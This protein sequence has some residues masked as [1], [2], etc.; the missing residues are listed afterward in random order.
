VHLQLMHTVFQALRHTAA[1]QQLL[2]LVMVN[3]LRSLPCVISWAGTAVGTSQNL[4]CG[5]HFAESALCSV[6]TGNVLCC[7]VSWAG[8][9]LCC[10]KPTRTCT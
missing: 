7:E 1:H 5:R 6:I 10:A 3:T 9:V 8:T 4:H 2:Q